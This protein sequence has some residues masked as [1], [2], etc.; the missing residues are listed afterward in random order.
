MLFGSGRGD[1]HI[2]LHLD[3]TET[4]EKGADRPDDPG[5]P[6]ESI[7]RYQISYRPELR[8][9]RAVSL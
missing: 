7:D 4:V 9:R 5:A 8:F 6:D 3:E 2:R 1:T